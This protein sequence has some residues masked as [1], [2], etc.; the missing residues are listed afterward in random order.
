M[1]LH[2]FGYLKYLDNKYGFDAKEEWSYYSQKIESASKFDVVEASALQCI[3]LLGVQPSLMKHKSR[4]GELKIP[5][6]VCMWYMTEFD[7]LGLAYIGDWFGGRDHSTVS[8][9]REHVNDMIDTKD[10]SYGRRI[11]QLKPLIPNIS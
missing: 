7:K 10:I 5:R 9:A 3:D 8:H 6:Q 4:K 11:K 2:N 1:R